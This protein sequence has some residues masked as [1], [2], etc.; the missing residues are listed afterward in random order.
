MCSDSPFRASAGASPAGV[1]PDAWALSVEGLSKCYR[2]YDH[3]RDRLLQGLVGRRRRLYREHWALRPL[4]FHLERGQTLGIVGRNGSGKSTLLQLICGTLAPTTGTVQVQGRIGA[5]LELGSG[6]NPEFSGRENVFLN[7]ALLG[8]RRQEVEARLD[9]ILAFADIGAFIDQP[10]KTY[11]SGMV[12]RL[13]F[14]VQAHIDPDLLVV[15]EALAV[16]DE[17]FQ[18]KCYGHLERLKER[19]TSILLVTHSCPQIIQHCDQALLLHRGHARQWGAPAPVTVNY[20]QLSGADDAAW[21]RVLGPPLDGLRLDCGVQT[22]E[23]SAASRAAGGSVAEVPAAEAPAA[24]LSAA[25]QPEQPRHPYLDPALQPATTI[26]YPSHGAR[27]EAV[28]IQAGS[29]EAISSSSSG[30]QEVNALPHG[31]PFSL[32]FTYVAERDLE[33]VSCSCHI[34]NH[35]GSRV[36]GQTYPL[37]GALIPRLAAGQRWQI[38]FHFHG[39]LWPGVYF[40]GGGIWSPLATQ[41]FIHRVVD[42]KALRIFQLDPL[43]VVGACDLTAAAP[44][45]QPLSP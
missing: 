17:L 18:K 29:G 36:T 5:L 34:A 1:V 3:P 16:G 33:Q 12:V 28:S 8:L 43:G 35:T 15:D 2:I 21:D 40:V 22:P 32:C 38:H 10:V 9:A 44:R 19:G 41:R 14:A 31:Q 7:A 27:I 23:R 30:G 6:F 4:S 45:L 26:V 39:G 11:S 24:G 25:A 37:A 42:Y 20:Q 13:A